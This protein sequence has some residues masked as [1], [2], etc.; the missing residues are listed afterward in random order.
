MKTIIIDGNNLIHK[1]PSIKKT[2]LISPEAAQL[3]LVESVLS[4]HKSKDKI[5]FVFDGFGKISK[6]NVIFSGKMSADEVIRKFI[7]D[8]YN[9][10]IITI[11]S[12][13]NDII[14]LAKICA[15]EV[16]KSE[17][18][19]NIQ[20]KSPLKGKNI[21]QLLYKEGE[22]PDRISKKELEEFKKYFT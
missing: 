19:W 13:D 6:E 7:E 18:F 4:K 16:I 12:S 1:I 22:K 21:N 3:S 5:I 11:V 14:R 2:F 20:E 8:Y 9:K 15:C 17:D 10:K